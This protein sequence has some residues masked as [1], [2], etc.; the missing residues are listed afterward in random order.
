MTRII[1]TCS[2]CG[3]PVTVP[4]VWMGV[5]SPT[6]TCSDC[7]ATAVPGPVIPMTPRR[8]PKNPVDEQVYWTH[9]Q[10]AT[11]GPKPEASAETRL[12]LAE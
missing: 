7:G 10:S 8:T 6:P 5:V 2:L 4:T 12:N 1:G 9:V 3:G 11:L